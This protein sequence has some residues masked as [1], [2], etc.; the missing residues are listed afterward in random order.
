MKPPPTN[1]RW[2]SIIKNN[3]SSNIF[4]YPM[5]LKTKDAGLVLSYIP[6]GV[7]DDQEPIIVGVEG[8][9]A[10]KANVYDFSDWTV[11][12]EWSDNNHL[13]KATSGMGMPFVYFTKQNND[14]AEIEINLGEVTIIDEIILVENA[15][16]NADFI[17]FAPGGSNWNQT[18]STYTS[19][20]NG[21]NYWS[22]AIDQ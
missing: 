22:I 8:L 6:W 1:D 7:Y 17:I 20:L 10:D 3:H 2:S 16:N 9:N 18:G 21:E 14:I 19:D 5:A 15:R 12:M 13:F 4:N 11:T